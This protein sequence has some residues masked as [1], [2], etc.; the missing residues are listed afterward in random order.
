M[1]APLSASSV[2]ETMAR[3]AE[4]PGGRPVV[5]SARLS[6]RKAAQ[7]D[8]LRGPLT[9]SQYA[10]WALERAID[11]GLAPGDTRAV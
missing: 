4:V 8:A 5:I 10:R 11:S 3:R 9:R 6:E 1:L 2:E 7:V